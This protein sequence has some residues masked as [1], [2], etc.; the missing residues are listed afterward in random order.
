MPR[1]APAAGR[2]LAA[3]RE[4]GAARGLDYMMKHR[5]KG[6]IGAAC[7]RYHGREVDLAFKEAAERAGSDYALGE[8]LSLGIFYHLAD[9]RARAVREITPWYEEHVKMFGPL[10]F[11]P[12][13]TPPKLE[14]S[15]LGG[16]LLM[17]AACPRFSTT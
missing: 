7:A 3:G 11:V 6:L 12:G 2:M 10:G 5:I 8:G 9:S 14:A 16:R 15:T 1:S 17:R 13:I 4:R